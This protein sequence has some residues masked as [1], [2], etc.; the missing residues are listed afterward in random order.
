MRRNRHQRSAGV[1]LVEVLVLILVIVVVLGLLIPRRRMSR[2]DSGWTESHNNIREIILAM[3]DHAS[4][5]DDWIPP[6]FDRQ[7]KWNGKP[8]LVKDSKED[9]IDRR[10]G[11]MFY[12]LLP[13][14]E[15][16]K[17]YQTKTP[18]DNVTASFKYYRYPGDPTN[19]LGSSYTSY[20]INPNM[21]G[22]MKLAD[23]FPR[24]F[25]NTVAIVE[26]AAVCQDGPRPWATTPDWDFDASGGPE[27]FT[28][29][30]G[31]R[32]ATAFTAF[33][34]STCCIGLL[35]GSVRRVKVDQPSFPIACQLKKTDPP[36]ELGPDW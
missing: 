4:Q 3:H 8:G 2:Y 34:D 5:H 23:S 20:A 15:G 25:S 32:F 6:G 36:T 14:I 1:R 13:Y 35:D 33:K 9:P 7:K 30:A 19:E 11:T 27:P 26:R 24:G 31:T 29:P 16:D 28:S 12:Y 10:G 21:E 17:L 18:Q 22:P